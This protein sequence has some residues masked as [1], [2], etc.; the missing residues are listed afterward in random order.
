VWIFYFF[1]H[2]LARISTNWPELGPD[3][4]KPAF[5][6]SS[7]AAAATADEAAMARQ[8][9]FGPAFSNIAATDCD[10]VRP[11]FA[12]KA[13][14]ATAGGLPGTEGWQ[15]DK[16]GGTPEAFGAD[17]PAFPYFCLQFTLVPP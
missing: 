5:A 8:A 3:K 1:W 11:A 13:F 10:A 17:F 15:K 4:A 9:S 7:F 2:E 12:P 16:L 6:A 14:G